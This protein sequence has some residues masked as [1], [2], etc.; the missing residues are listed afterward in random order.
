[1]EA[2]NLYQKLSEAETGANCSQ[3]QPRSTSYAPDGGANK[4]TKQEAIYQF[5]HCIQDINQDLQKKVQ[6]VYYAKIA[7]KLKIE[8]EAYERSQ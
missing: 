6:K 7:K 3:Q 2:R 4:L 1:L 8:E 5:K